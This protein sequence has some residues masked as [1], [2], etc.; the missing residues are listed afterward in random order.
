MRTYNE[1]HSHL[2]DAYREAC[3]QSGRD[4]TTCTGVIGTGAG[5]LLCVMDYPAGLLMIFGGIAALIY[6]YKYFKK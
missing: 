1:E 5:I 2:P 4:L 6:G 3:R